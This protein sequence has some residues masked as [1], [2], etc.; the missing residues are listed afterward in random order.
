MSIRKIGKI[1]GVTCV[2]ALLLMLLL[3]L[4]LK[5]ALDR[6][7]LYQ[8]E[9]KD[10]VHAQTG[11]HIGFARVSSAFRWY[12]PE[13][14]FDQLELR[15]KDDQRVLARA[16]GGR[17]AADIWQLVRSGKL[18]AGRIEIESPKI[19]VV[20]LGP[21]RFA[22]A[23]EIESGGDSSAFA[24][25]KLD[26]LPAGRVVIR[27]AEVT[28]ENW[29]VALPQLIVQEV[30]IDARRDAH[31]FV[32]DFS[33]R[34]PALLGGTVAFKGHA[35]GSGDLRTLAWDAL[36][37][38]RD[39][40]FPGWHQLLPDYL[41][42]LDSGT[43]SFEAAA[44]GLGAELSRADADF[45]AL[46]VVTRLP[47]GPA[48]KFD[49]MSGALTLLH[50]GDRWSLSGK[51]VR[52]GRGDPESAFV[53]SWQESVGG[54]LSVRTRAS[55]LRAETLLPLMGLL[56]QKELRNRLREIAPSGEWT[57]T[58][59]AFERDEVGEP[60]RM[61]VQAKFQR[62]GFAAVGGRPGLRGIKGSIDGNERG[63]HVIIDTNIG[64]FHGP[65]QFPRP[66]E[67]ERLKA[68]F[69][70]KRTPQ[71]LLIASPDWEVKTHDSDMHVQLAWHQPA[72]DAS[73]K[74]T[75]VSTIESGNIV[76][77]KNYLPNGLIGAGAL[78][79][80]NR[81]FLSGHLR[82]NA[83]FQGSVKSFPFRDG[84]GIFLAR[85]SIEGMTLDYSDGWPPAE[86]LNA[87]AEFRNQGMS[88]RLSQARLG[89]LALESADAYF[90]DFSNGELR[91]HAVGRGDASSALSYLRA[92]P[93]EELSDHAFSAVE[94]TGPM[95]ATVDLFLPFKDFVHRQALVHGRLNGATV[96]KPG[97]PLMA[98]N[99]AGDFDIDGGQVA[100]ADLHGQLLGG[101]FQMQAR[102]ARNKP[103]TRTQLE[104]RGTT[105]ADAL[106]TAWSIPASIS[107]GGQTDWRAVLKIA[108]EPSRE[109]SLRLSSTLVGFEL[110]LPAPLDKETATP[111]P[112][113]LEIQWPAAGGPKG[114]FA[115]GSVVSGSYVLESDANGLRLA[116]ASMSFG[117]SE[118]A[119]V[120]SQILTVGGSIERLDLGGWLRLSAP[121]KGGKPLAYYMRDA[122]VHVA[123]LDY[124]G[125]AF[126]DVSLDLAITD[127]IWRINVGGPNV[128]GAV[129]VPSTANST[130]A[131][132]LQF[133]RLRVDP[134]QN[135]EPTA[136]TAVGVAVD[137]DPRAV[138][139]VN[140]RATELVFGERQLGEV[141]AVLAKEE[142]GVGLR[143]L[144]VAGSSYTVSAQGEWRAKDAG[145]SRLKGTLASTDVQNTLK[146]LG[147]ADV[148]QAKSGK[149]DFDLTWEG[150]PTVAALAQ[151]RGHVQLSLEKGQVTGIKPGAG[152][153]LGLSSIAAL[154]RRLA[155][156][157]SDLT[158]KGL[159]FDS[160]HGDFDLRDGNAYTENV[161]LKGPAAEI[162]LIGRTGLKNR[163]YDQTAVVTG[164]VGSSLSIPVASALVGGPVVGAAVLL[165][166]QVFKQPLKGL[167]RGY[168]HITGS[169]DNPTVERI[170]S[171][172]AAA[173][174]AEAPK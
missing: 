134:A 114:S 122:S 99:L 33:A 162:G 72:D 7:P 17:V 137:T 28:M 121:D 43:G 12:G 105:A 96:Q 91:I 22:V 48:A 41:S 16:A 84:G 89:D 38:G 4:A 56:P 78:A 102:T 119:A 57:D 44:Q 171:A 144:S 129:T 54:L 42:N 37:R 20:R 151:A 107:L 108:P 138:P 26:D 147:Y 53:V 136:A 60:W 90:P 141:S 157:F 25:L 62:A 86:N 81:A 47:Q 58:A 166:T 106:R 104:F 172:D 88:A 111:L 70:W 34:L 31:D 76:N 23:S 51:R 126:R 116:H 110:K 103:V 6:A 98:T 59:L 115:L 164:S 167:A 24:T 146:D 19:A 75:L 95:Q 128:I 80:L 29:S 85:C 101:G 5:L 66:V 109:R 113:W 46:N 68:D 135:S 52:V 140:F 112:S 45:R 8:A 3:T 156:D 130:E 94:A 155:L 100:R 92:T 173:A 9:I 149:M 27:H 153:V 174:P 160:V 61:Q 55:Y 161:L 118:P 154:P 139:S 83:I 32:W 49:Q 87:T 170:K 159:A 142:F 11:Y 64:V 2:A 10:W 168:Y 39:I 65:T 169:W 133:D 79:W 132:N 77:A 148:I 69:Y 150:A 120:G 165:F 131:W 15:S 74:L 127:R 71:E 30:G 1:F 35:H 143:H 36:A 73:P 14:Y 63:G 13:L 40:S 93:L 67:L 125:L 145:V 152:R 50:A 163:D 123:E 18:L 117:A 124:L 158:D 97:S 21:S 82:A